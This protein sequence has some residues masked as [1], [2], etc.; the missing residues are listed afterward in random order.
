MAVMCG[1]LCERIG[2]A[3]GAETVVA[4]EAPSVNGF[5]MLRGLGVPP[6]GTG[7]G[8]SNVSVGMWGMAVCPVV[9]GTDLA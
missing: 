8:V 3:I 1:V 5:G 6:G 4:A 7:A 9:S 2:D